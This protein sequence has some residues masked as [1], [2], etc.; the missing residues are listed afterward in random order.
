[1]RTREM[2]HLR[3]FTLKHELLKIYVYFKT[4]YAVKTHLAE[5]ATECE[6]TYGPGRKTNADCFENR[7]A[8]FSDSKK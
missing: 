3:H 6:V 4:A 8:I 5:E 2:D 1:M 7:E